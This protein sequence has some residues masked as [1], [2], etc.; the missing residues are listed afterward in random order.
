MISPMVVSIYIKDEVA[1]FDIAGT[2]PVSGYYQ[3]S[4]DKSLIQE[5]IQEIYQVASRFTCPDELSPDQVLP[6]RFE[7]SSE[8]L[9][10]FSKLGRIIHTQCIP[11]QI[12]YILDHTPPS[13][14]IFR[15]DAGLMDIPWE[16]A[17]DGN[18]YLSMR[19]C[20]SRQILIV[21]PTDKLSHSISK[22]VSYPIKILI[23]AD[24]SG[25]LSSVNQEVETLMD[26]LDNLP[27]FQVEVIGGSRATRFHILKLIESYDIIHF[28]GHSTMDLENPDQSGWNLSDGFLCASDFQGLTTPPMMIFSNSCASAAAGLVFGPEPPSIGHLGLGGGFLLAGVRHFVGALWV[29]HDVSSAKFAKYVYQELLNGN[30]IGVACLS[31]R[32]ECMRQHPELIPV[33]SAYVHYGDPLDVLI[34]DL[35]CRPPETESQIP[36]S[37]SIS[38]S[39]KWETIAW[40]IL[41]LVSGVGLSIWLWPGIDQAPAEKNMATKQP[42]IDSLLAEYEKALS[43]YRAYRIDESISVLGHLIRRPENTTGIGLALLSNIYLE[44]GL[45]HQADIYL[46]K[47]LSKNPSD[48]LS[49]V[50]KGEKL[51]AAGNASE[52]E[53]SFIRAAESISGN[54]PDRARA[55]NCR[56]F[57][58]FWNGDMPAAMM[59]F[60]TALEVHPTDIDALFNLAFLSFIHKDYLTA[61]QYL[62]QL[63]KSSLQDGMADWLQAILGSPASENDSQTAVDIL[64]I[65]PILSR[66]HL[67][68]I[69]V[70][71]ILNEKIIAVLKKYFPDKV[72]RPGIPINEQDYAIWKKR[73]DHNQLA[74]LDFSNRDAQEIIFGEFSQTFHTVT[75]TIKR[76]QANSG[77]VIFTQTI[78]GNGPE[79]MDTLLDG[80]IQAI[81]TF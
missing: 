17:F 66:G 48:S 57:M 40:I 49:L 11:Q 71:R 2:T 70:E 43:D 44:V 76:I 25:T 64:A 21:N 59:F 55:W 65:P 5:V 60:E 32:Q 42:I 67:N 45:L 68:R 13:H 20:L 1:I 50:L 52:A 15:L 26:L 69:G 19:F 75:M 33:W 38:D 37:A 28:A 56:G 78:F 63:R 3:Q 58:A 31:A 29:I 53:S 61:S 22:P 79:K 30:S 72:I 7:I 24:P 34:P 39:S 4:I 36:P 41:F 73:F 18:A 35:G 16:I 10:E 80:L 46:E 62:E 27:Q 51:W 8:S 77:Q 23:I 6:S 54:P 74:S 47:A 81:K 14:L 12:R 9:S